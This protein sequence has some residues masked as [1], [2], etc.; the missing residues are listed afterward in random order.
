MMAVMIAAL[1]LLVVAAVLVLLARAARIAWR[2]RRL[3]GVVWQRIRPRHVLGSLGLVV[4]V[5]TTALI[6]L[7]AVPLTR[8]GAGT[9][10]GLNGNAVFAPLEEAMARGGGDLGAGGLGAGGDAARPGGAAALP[11]RPSPWAMGLATVFLGG[12]LPLIPWL[13]Y[14]EERAFREGLERAGTGRQV[15]RAVKFGLVHLVMLIPLAAALAIAVA[16]FAYGRVYRREYRRAAARTATV[17]GPLG[18]P[19]EVHPSP[20]RCRHAA[21]LESTTWHVT[22]NS[23]IVLLVLLGLA[24]GWALAP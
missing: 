18:A 11:A 24:A 12:L 17:T 15:L 1:R 5:L 3:A 2:N 20:A 7:E 6:L 21:V 9:F 8:L 22:F 14:V 23:L 13:A 16:G 19:V 10:L 4:A